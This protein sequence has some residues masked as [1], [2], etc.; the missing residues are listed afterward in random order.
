MKILHLIK[1]ALFSFSYFFISM[2][3]FRALSNIV[4]GFITNVPPETSLDVPTVIL[5]C[6]SIVFGIFMALVMGGTHY[7]KG[8]TCKVDSSAIVIL[9]DTAEGAVNKCL[10]VIGS[11]DSFR[12]VK[13]DINQRFLEVRRSANLWTFGDII[14]ISFYDNG[15]KQQIIEIDSIPSLPTTLVDYGSNR[16]NVEYIC[17]KLTMISGRVVKIA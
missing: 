8:G 7:A 2:F 15:P 16:R 10:E 1:I 12:K 13:G 5:F 3:F 11:H 4:M 9:D 17:A 14:R 6:S